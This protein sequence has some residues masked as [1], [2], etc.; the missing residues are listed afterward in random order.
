MSA[1]ELSS[2]KAIMGQFKFPQNE[3]LAPGPEIVSNKQNKTSTPTFVSFKENKR[4]FG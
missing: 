3:S 2:N 1:I 4:L